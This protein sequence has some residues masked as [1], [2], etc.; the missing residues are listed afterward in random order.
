M[1]EISSQSSNS[2]N[3]TNQIVKMKFLVVISACLAVSSG[4]ILPIGGAYGGAFGGYY[5]GY[6]GPLADVAPASAHGL[7]AHPNGA[8]TPV[9]TP[10]V[11]AAR[12][13]H[14]AAKGAIYAAHAPALVA[15]P[16][17]PAVAPGPVYGGVPAVAAPAPALAPVPA[18]GYAGYVGPLAD[19]L[20]AG[21]AGLVAHP[22][23]AVT[24]AD[25][26][27]VVAARS[28]HL[29]ARGAAYAAAAPVLAYGAAPAIA[30]PAFASPAIAA[31]AI[32]APAIAAGP[33]VAPYAAGVIP[34][35]AGSPTG[36]LVSFPNGAVVPADEPAV[37][38]AR[39]DHLAAKGPLGW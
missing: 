36:A 12:A 6:A 31:P 25:T 4:S 16:A 18:I 34:V 3:T 19:A 21:A 8:V 10:S 33:V 15:A 39:A 1:V 23:G 22:N 37:A 13:D 27:S 26:P 35:G 7:V 5:P 38:A 17:V 20:P 29:A 11:V 9:D 30:A 28:D 14:L 32:A 2:A 24:P